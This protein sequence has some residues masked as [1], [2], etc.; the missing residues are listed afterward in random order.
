MQISA[1][2]TYLDDLAV[3]LRHDAPVYLLVVLHALAG[4]VFLEAVGA[5]EMVSYG[6]YLDRWALRTIL[7]FPPALILA[8]YLME[9][10]RTGGT[11]RAA[12]AR[13]VAPERVAAISAG[14]VMLLAFMLFQGAFTSVK[15]GLSVL[16]GGFPFDLAQANFDKAIHFGTDPWRLLYRFAQDETLLAIVE[17]NYGVLWFFLSFGALVVAILAPAGEMR[18]R[19]LICFILVWVVVGNIVAGLFMS[20][21]PAFYGFVTGDTARYAEQLAWLGEFGG[22]SAYYQAYLWDLQ[23]AGVTGFGSGISAFPSVHVALAALNAMFAWS[24][25]RRLGLAAWG[26]AAFVQFSSV[27][28]A[29]HYA[30]DG[31]AGVVLAALIY[32]G[33]SKFMQARASEQTT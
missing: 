15:N 12:L 7:F 3:A 17:W 8:S 4:L 9:L 22:G 26:Y 1:K 19:Y 10:H 27:Y 30:I 24:L 23:E 31:Y 16:W 21:G 14:L 11:R 29:W 28:L 25:D 20:A 5:A 13:A 33:L 6:L 18:T 2:A 32:V